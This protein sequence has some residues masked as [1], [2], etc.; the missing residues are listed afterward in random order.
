MLLH[1]H[2]AF[3]CGLH[4]HGSLDLLEIGVFHVLLDLEADFAKGLGGFG[5]RSWNFPQGIDI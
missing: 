1:F 2:P 3:E 4:A 5:A